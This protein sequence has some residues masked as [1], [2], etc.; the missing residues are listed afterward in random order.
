MELALYTLLYLIVGF[1]YIVLIS[2]CGKGFNPDP[3]M[4]GP[5][6]EGEYV[7]AVILWPLSPLMYVVWWFVIQPVMFLVEY[8]GGGIEWCVDR[9]KERKHWA[10]EYKRRRKAERTSY[11]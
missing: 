6:S 5:D 9:C 4:A 8:G 3:S 10:R 1:V 11:D 2:C 7:S